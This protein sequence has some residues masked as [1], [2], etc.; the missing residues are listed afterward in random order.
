MTAHGNWRNSSTARP[1]GLARLNRIRW[2]CRF[3]GWW[4]F[5]FETR[6]WS[7][8]FAPEFAR[9][10]VGCHILCQGEK[11]TVQVSF[12]KFAGCQDLLMLDNAHHSVF[13]WVIYNWNRFKN[14]DIVDYQ[15]MKQNNC[16]VYTFSAHQKMPKLRLTLEL[17]MTPFR[18][19]MNSR[20]VLTL[21]LIS[22]C[23]N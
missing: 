1:A 2:F 21:R 6:K 7:C 12:S 17:L 19:Q 10:M 11:M 14:I 20:K 9:R 13:L 5:L 22:H 23:F 18:A 8:R 16:Q 3:F 15:K 4:H